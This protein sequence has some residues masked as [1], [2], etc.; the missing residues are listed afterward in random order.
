MR[1]R[2]EPVIENGAL[3]CLHFSLALSTGEIID[4]NFSGQAASFRLGDGSM[5]P[6]F[7]AL[8]VGLKTGEEIE[9]LL[10]AEQAF[11]PVN[12]DNRH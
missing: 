12:P 7:E 4:S 3:I 2:P 5:L 8:L 6:G 1:Q 10:Q 11:E 9:Q